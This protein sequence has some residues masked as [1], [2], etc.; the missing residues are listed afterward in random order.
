MA[1]AKDY[2]ICCALFN[3]YI[4]KV[5]KKDNN[6][7]TDDRREISDEEIFTLIDWKLGQFVSEH[8]ESHGFIFEGSDGRNIKVCYVDD[9]KESDNT[10]EK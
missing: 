3:A 10:E 4:A 9:S 6:L 5:S 1:T 2:Q 7:M 8:E